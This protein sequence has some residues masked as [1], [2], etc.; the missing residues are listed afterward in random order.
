MG[1]APAEMLTKE[2]AQSQLEGAEGMLTKML[3]NTRK[4]YRGR[5]VHV[6]FKMCTALNSLHTL[7]QT[8]STGSLTLRR[9]GSEGRILIRI[10]QMSEPKLGGGCDS[11]NVTE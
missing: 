2:Q 9:G 11:S 1:A 4:L 8:T 5:N 6:P 10:L 7:F 3:D